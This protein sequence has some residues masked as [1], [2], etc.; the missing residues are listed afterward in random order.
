MGSK[1]VHRLKDKD[2]KNRKAFCLGCK[3]IVDLTLT[4]YGVFHCLNASRQQR[5]NRKDR[6]YRLKIYENKINECQRCKTKNEDYRF[7]DIHH[8]D[9]NHNNYNDDNLEILCPNCHRL[10]TIKIWN[11]RTR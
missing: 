4:K 3:K 11:N 8:I 10:E 9:R 1:W 6:L 7:F 2:V 5:N